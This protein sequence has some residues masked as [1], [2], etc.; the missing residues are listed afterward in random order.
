MNLSLPVALKSL[1]NKAFEILAPHPYGAAELDVPQPAVA[2][3]VINCRRRQL[4]VV[5]Y[6]FNRHQLQTDVCRD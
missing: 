6:L 4:A 5:G 2:E 3:P 1:E